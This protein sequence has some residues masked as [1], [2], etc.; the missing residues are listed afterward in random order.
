[1]TVF[2]MG[3]TLK[4]FIS[5]I[6]AN[7][8]ELLGKLTYNP[9]SYKTLYTGSATIPAKSSGNSATITLSDNITKFDG[10]IIQREGC[11][12]WQTVQTIAVGNVFKVMNSESDF[13]VMEGCNLYMCNVKVKTATQ[14][15]LNN[16]VYA[17]I[18]TSAVGR[19]LTSFTERP[20]TKVIGIKF[21]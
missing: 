8:S 16:N 10:V 19:Y 12:C 20:I 18:K 3:T 11:S 7:F 13:D 17:G 4:S 1:M 9:I 2:K 5:G 14:L 21:N 15:Q 6:N